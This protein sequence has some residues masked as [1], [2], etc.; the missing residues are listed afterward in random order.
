MSDQ[1]KSTERNDQS[2]NIEIPLSAASQPSKVKGLAVRCGKNAA[3][4]F[5]EKMKTQGRKLGKCI[6]FKGK[7]VTPTEFES[8]SQ[9][10]AKKWKQSIKFQGKP[11]GDW[12]AVNDIEIELLSQESRRSLSPGSNPEITAHTIAH[13]SPYRNTETAAPTSVLNGQDSAAVLSQQQCSPVVQS[14]VTRVESSERSHTPL[15]N[16]EFTQ[17]M[18]ELEAKLLSSLREII[19]QT[20]ES[21]RE[22]VAVELCAFRKEIESV[23]GRVAALESVGAASCEPAV[24]P[25]N[26]NTTIESTKLEE[27]ESIVQS[28]SSKH[29]KIERDK[30]REK[31]KCN[32]LI[33]NIEEEELMSET[34]TE[35]LVKDLFQ[36]TLK[37]EFMPLQAVRIG[38]K[39]DTTNHLILVKMMNSMAEKIAVLKEAKHLRGTN[40]YIREDLSIDER[41]RRKILIDEMKK[42]RKDGRRAY[43]RFSDGNL[44]VDGSVV[45]VTSTATINSQ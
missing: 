20:I 37:L 4:F 23:T 38:R 42:A 40:T 18:V 21:L 8:M 19:K 5:P 22:H 2:N 10:Q 12:L 33:G 28:L 30:E 34:S 25:N 14:N 31:R 45:E 44:I 24:Q 39:N 15:A 32:L 9:V 35:S 11:I 7:W 36:N 16:V 1:S 43:I 6:Q 41:K 27:L 26:S 29:E 3:T 17:I 13:N